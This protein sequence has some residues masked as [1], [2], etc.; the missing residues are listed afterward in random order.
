MSFFF[1]KV[2]PLILKS[3]KNVRVKSSMAMKMYNADFWVK[4]G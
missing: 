4:K 1:P 2:F 3:T